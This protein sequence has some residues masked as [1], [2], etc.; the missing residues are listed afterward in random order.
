MEEYRNVIIQRVAIGQGAMS[1]QRVWA[2]CNPEKVE[3]M[4][5]NRR[6]HRQAAALA[7]AKAEAE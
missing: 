7:A 5:E 1:R 4:A 2:I 6:K 3:Q